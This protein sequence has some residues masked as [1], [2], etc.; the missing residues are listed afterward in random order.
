[1]ATWLQS[2]AGKAGKYIDV[3][4]KL[5]PIKLPELNI[6]ESLQSYGGAPKNQPFVYVRPVQAASTP[7]NTNY[8]QVPNYSQ[9]P[10]VLGTNT[11]GGGGAQQPAQQLAGQ[12]IA[13]ND[14]NRQVEDFGA[15]IDRDYDTAMQGLQS[16]E[17]SLSCQ[18]GT[19]EAKIKAQYGTAKTAIGAEQAAKEAGV[20]KE[21]STAST[22]AKTSTQQ[23]RD[24][25]REIQQQNIA[26]TSGL[27][28][29][30]S[31]VTEALA[32]RLGVETARRIAGITGTFNEVKQN[33]AAE[34]TRVQTYYKQKL[35]DLEESLG[36]G[37][38][39][40][41]ESLMAGIREIN[42]AR[43]V[44]A[45]DKANRR[46][47]LLS[48]AQ[49]AMANLQANAQQF[50]QSLQIWETQ[51]TSALQSIS[52][53]DTLLAQLTSASEYFGQKPQFSE[54]SF[55]PQ[56]SYDKYG[57]ISGQLTSKPKEE[58]ELANP[59]QT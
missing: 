42:Q 13:S 43:N 29:S 19:A 8:S 54:F 5:S 36:A 27:G 59:F 2:L 7:V 6:S 35:A 23:A 15:I 22:S 58:E 30:S 34:S 56:V 52:S 12:D 51:K 14:I 3:A 16:Q 24:L 46:A 41:Q 40:I 31:S 26:S 17:E 38:G 9:A 10:Q 50:A 48:N 39:S 28:I 4:S 47:E 11:G 53:N 55:F 20:Q 1:M 21:L 25:F 33:L 32:E 44:A 18:A 57:N 37:I 49:S 45:T